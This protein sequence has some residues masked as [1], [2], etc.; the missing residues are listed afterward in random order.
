MSKMTAQCPPNIGFEAGTFEQWECFVGEVDHNG[1]VNMFLQ[2]VFADRHTMIKNDGYPVLDPYGHFPVNCPNGSSYSIKLGNDGVS[3]EAE[4]VR[5]TFVVPANQNDY[6][7]VYNYAVVLQDPGHLPYQQ[8]RFT[9]KVFDVASGQY[10]PCSS[11]D[12]IASYALP[13]FS[14]SD[15]P[16]SNGAQNVYYKPWA[17]ASINL[18]GYAGKT[19]RLEF[20]TNDCT[21]GEHFGYAYLDINDNCQ[22]VITGNKYCTGSS[23]II[24]SAPFGYKEYHW[25]DAGLTTLLGNENTLRIA[26]V[27]P[28]GTVYGL[29]IKPYPG[30]GCIDTLYTTIQTVNAAFN[31]NIPDSV[32]FCLP[33]PAN[34]T[35]SFITSG[36]SPGLIYSY[37]TDSSQINP[38]YHPEA[39]TTTGIYYIKATANN[40]CTDIKPVTIIIN[41]SPDFTVHDPPHVDYPV[42][43]DITSP[44]IITGYT[45]GL[46]F[47]YWKDPAAT[48]PLSDP[49]NVDMT[50]EYFIK[51]AA[52][53]GC[54]LI[55]P[56]NVLIGGLR[57]PN[58]FTP[59]NDGHNDV[60]GIPGLK[61][62][63]QCSVRV[64]DRWG[65]LVF[66]SIGYNKPWDGKKNGKLLPAGT[67]CYMIRIP[68]EFQL[69]SG[70]ITIIY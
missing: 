12:F 45:Y 53:S 50:G 59:N 35:S 14:L 47:S 42:K 54:S 25:Y 65:Q 55:R 9:A 15:I 21:E 67:Y 24:L 7:I 17:T 18:S 52:E 63:P 16:A 43:V 49:R 33:A 69:L 29:I 37:F 58:A 8:P 70:T 10:V 23:S 46:S 19:I 41:N 28:P 61:Q 68:G 26:P 44:S 36:S 38:V 13:G 27:P 60:W 64:F 4:Q 40:G 32:K 39:L 56:V 22:S 11:Y 2:G 51:A 66:Y 48:I 57:V 30:S 1:K 34:L 5:Y 20:T 62:F 31:F 6:S 3:S